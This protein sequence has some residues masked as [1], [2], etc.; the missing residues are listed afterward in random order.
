MITHRT[1]KETFH[2]VLDLPVGVAEFAVV[3]SG[4]TT[5]AGLLATF[6]LGPPC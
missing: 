4:L 3:V 6:L 2:L 5:G 1:W